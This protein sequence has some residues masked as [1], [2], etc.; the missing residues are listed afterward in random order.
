MYD[1]HCDGLCIIDVDVVIGPSLVVQG[2]IEQ[3]ATELCRCL[4]PGSGALGTK[5]WLDMVCTEICRASTCTFQG[6]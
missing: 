2:Y 1:K 5:T 3:R 4:N 6:N